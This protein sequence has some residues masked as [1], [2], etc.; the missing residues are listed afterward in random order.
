MGMK[1]TTRLL[2]NLPSL[3]FKDDVPVI[4]KLMLKNNMTVFWFSGAD[5]A[6]QVAPCVILFVVLMN[7][8]LITYSGLPPPP[9]ISLYYM[10]AVV[11]SHCLCKR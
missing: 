10:M 6:F 2:L 5:I 8:N 11:L 9:I 4:F 1:D 7:C 3:R